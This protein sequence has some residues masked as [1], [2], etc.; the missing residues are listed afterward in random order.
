MAHS[1]QP[2]K[3]C[4]KERP[5]R[6]R[7]RKPK[8]P[9]HDTGADCSADDMPEPVAGFRSQMVGATRIKINRVPQANLKP[10]DTVTRGPFFLKEIRGNISICA[11]CSGQ[12]MLPPQHGIA[13]PTYSDITYCLGH[14]E[15]YY[16]YNKNYGQWRLSR[17]NK[18]YHICDACVLPRNPY[19]GD[20][21][22]VEIHLDHNVDADQEL[23]DIVYSRFGKRI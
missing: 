5:T 8:S 1:Q 9:V 3:K 23:K 16:Y 15:V 11:G 22:L 21:D 13:Q 14:F 10:T 7:E 12:R 6:Q 17:G 4:W 2:A 18:H 19:F 20:K